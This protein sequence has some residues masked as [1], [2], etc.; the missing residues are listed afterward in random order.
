MQRLAV[1]RYGLPDDEARSLVHDIFTAYIADPATIRG[2][3]RP[4]FVG[5]ICNAS[6]AYWRKRGRET[7][8][9]SAEELASE[10][11]TDGEKRDLSLDLDAVISQLAPHCQAT[12]RQFYFEGGTCDEIAAA[13]HTSRA[14][15]HQ[16]L[17]SCRARIRA[18]LKVRTKRGVG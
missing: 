15:V 9:I 1:N 12:I 8:L 5:A 7:P 10:E 14:H 4:Y 17:H 2:P 3:L 16:I 6:R 11:H 13:M 18:L